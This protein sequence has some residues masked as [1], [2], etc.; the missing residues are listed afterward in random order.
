MDAR[1]AKTEIEQLWGQLQATCTRAA[2]SEQS[3][4]QSAI[5]DALRDYAGEDG[6]RMLD[7]LARE[8]QHEK[9]HRRFTSYTNQGYP[10]SARTGAMLLICE[11]TARG[12]DNAN[13]PPATNFIIWRD[14]A[15]EAWLLGFMLRGYLS[16]EWIKRAK[17]LD[18]SAIMNP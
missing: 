6:K 4:D 9:G 18:Y 14:T 8:I 7:L 15:A 1:K 10:L 17:A 13:M 2:A 12:T 16:P 3:K 5:R 11:N